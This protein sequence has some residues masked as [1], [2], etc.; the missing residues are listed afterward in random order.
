[1]CSSAA[2]WCS[3]RAAT[4]RA[5]NICSP[6]QREPRRRGRHHHRGQG[7]AAYA[8]RPRGADLRADRRQL[9]E[10]DVLSGQ[11]QEIPR[12]GT[13]LPETYKFTRGMSREQI[14]PAHAAGARSVCCRKSGSTACRICRSRR[15]NNWSSSPRS[16]RRKP[17]RPDER[18]RVAAVFV[19][20][21]KNKH[22]AAVRSDH[23]L[24]PGR[25]ARARSA[26]RS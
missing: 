7:G 10:A 18:S 16:S 15:R 21:L 5:A 23:H 8:H 19:N 14:D 25:A 6:R 20:R 2:C 3:R 26:A 12:E 22:E 11:I 9:L 17:A 4:S 24:R 13:L 1:M